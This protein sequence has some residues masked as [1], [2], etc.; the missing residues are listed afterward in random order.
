MVIATQASVVTAHRRGQSSL[1]ALGGLGLLML[2]FVAA[3]PWIL[4]TYDY[5]RL[6]T[7]DR[8]LGRDHDG[9]RSAGTF[10]ARAVGVDRDRC[11][12]GRDAAARRRSGT[13]PVH[14]YLSL[15]VGRPRAGRRH[16]PLRV[17]P[18][19]RRPCGRCATLR[20]IPTSIA[21]TMPSRPIRR[22]RRCSSLP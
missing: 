21:R 19:R 9:G 16:Q 2:A 14:G 17:R 4:R 1:L 3:A 5:A 7:G 22:S 10:R 11:D 15:R 6:C 18:G 12:G 13:V 8:S 20:S